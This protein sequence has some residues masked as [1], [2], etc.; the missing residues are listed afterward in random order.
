MTWRSLIPFGLLAV[1][2][3]G[4]SGVDSYYGRVAGRS[5]NGTGVLAEALRARG[6]TVTSALVL[7]ERLDKANV[8]V[9]FATYPGPPDED[10]ADWYEA[11][12]DMA[13]DRK[14]IYVS[15]DY[16]AEP[17]YWRAALA[18]MP[19]DSDP[20]RRQTIEGQAGASRSK[21]DGPMFRPKKTGRVD[22]W[23]AMEPNPGGPT[24][25]QTLAGPWA[26]GVDAAKARITRHEVPKATVEN[27]LLQGDGKVLA[28]DWEMNDNARVLVVANGSF[29]LNAALLDRARRPLAERVVA[30]VG[31]GPQRIVFVEGAFPLDLRRESSGLVLPPSMRSVVAHLLAFALIGCLAR[32]A[33]LGRPRAPAPSDAERPVAHAEALGDLLAKTGEA[34]A[35]RALIE[36]YRRWRTP[37]AH[38]STRKRAPGP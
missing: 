37:S 2:G 21:S 13:P 28:M 33:R 14:M 15:R 20:E 10:E 27:V 4:P 3:C 7:D 12:L 30:W 32:T 19:A 16:D 1:A 34:Q 18:A 22:A 6:H 29:L 38:H 24:V 9:R 25:C 17:D 11:W 8:L 35:A 26:S 5:V 23:F 36:T 31:A